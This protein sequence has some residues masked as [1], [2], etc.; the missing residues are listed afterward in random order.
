MQGRRLVPNPHYDEDIQNAFDQQ[1]SDPQKFTAK[2]LHLPTVGIN[3]KP[4][5]AVDAHV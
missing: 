1:R 2:T 4:D 3:T 5:V